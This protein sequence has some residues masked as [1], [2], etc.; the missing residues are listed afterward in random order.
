MEV[1]TYWKDWPPEHVVGRMFGQFYGLLKAP[2]KVDVQVVDQAATAD[3]MLAA[4][5]LM[6]GA[7][8]VA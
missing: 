7:A 2:P 1:L 5:R 6:F 3:E 8:G 4:G